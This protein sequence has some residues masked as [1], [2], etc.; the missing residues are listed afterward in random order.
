[1]TD[2]TIKWMCARDTIGIM[3]AY[4]A[5]DFFSHFVSFL[6]V[7]ACLCIHHIINIMHTYHKF[8]PANHPLADIYFCHPNIKSP[9]L[10]TPIG[11]DFS[12]RT[13]I[14]KVLSKFFKKKNN[15]TLLFATHFLPH[16]P[17]LFLSLVQIHTYTQ[18]LEKY[19]IW[20]HTWI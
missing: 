14:E 3:W 8:S 9:A 4:D 18:M 20:V 13:K 2:S 10:R 6:S 16:Q 7:F 19:D 5:R 15:L 17:A 12:L 11:K 1:M